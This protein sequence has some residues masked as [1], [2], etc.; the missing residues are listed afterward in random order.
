MIHKIELSGPRKVHGTV[1][2]VGISPALLSFLRGR[3]RLSAVRVD[4]PDLTIDALEAVKEQKPASRP[5]PLQSL[6]PFLASLASEA[7]GLAVEI[8][9]GRLATSR[10]GMNLAVL[11]GLDASVTVPPTGPRTLHAD[12]RVS[13]S[14]L[15][16]RRTDREVL[17]VGGLRVEG[18]LEAGAG[19]TVVTLS[20]L[21]TESPRFLAEVALSVSSAGP[22]ADVTARGSGLDVT[23]LRGRLLS[24]AGD[25][26]TIAA[27]FAIF[28]GGTLS[29]F[30]FAAGG[31]TPGDLGIFER[32]SIQAVLADGNVRIGS[33][34]LDLREAQ[35]EVAVEKGVLSAVHVTARLGRS[36]VSDGSVRIGLGANDDTLQVV[37]TVR[38]DLA[39]LPG[40]LS[41]AVRGRSF[42]EKLSLVEDLAGIAT[43]RIT[44]GDR[45]GALETKVSVSEMQLSGRYR[46]IPW[47]IRIRQ[48]TFF[49]DGNRVGV[50]ELSGNIGGSTLSGLVA[51]VRLGNAPL[52]EKVSGTIQ[53]TLDELFPWLA[54]RKGMEA[55]QTEVTGL[56]GSI[57]L[58]VS[59]LS[60]PIS[61]PA[62]WQYEATGSLKDLVLATSFLP[63]TL[64]VKSGGFRID[65]DT[66]RVTGLEART[67]DA[68]LRVSGVLAGLRRGPRKAEAAVDGVTGPEAVGWI[69][70]KASLPA[71]FLPAA[72]ITLREVRVGLAEDTLT[73]AG[74]FTFRNGP[75]VELDVLKDGEGTDVRRLTIADSFSDASISLGLRRKELAVGFN[76]RL[77][78]PTLEEL[79]ARK[80]RRHG[81]IEGEF[82]AL[83][84]WDHIGKTSASGMLKAAD[85]VIPTPAGEITIEALDV[86]A[87]GNRLTASSSSLA[88]DD[89]HLSL[90]G[91]VTFQEEGIVLDMDAATGGIAWA[92]VEKVLDRMNSAKKAA[93]G[94]KKGEP[95][96]FPIGGILRLSI[97]SFAFRDLAWRPVLADIELAKESIT[98]T[99]RKAEVCGISTTG[100]LRFL[101]GG[102]VSGVARVA[103]M[104]PDINVPL[105]C[106]GFEN[107]RMTGPY[108]ASLQVEGKG[109]AAELP[110][111]I[112][113]PLTFRASNGRMGKASVLTKVLAAVNLTEVFK[114]KARDHL[115]ET[116]PF[117]EFTVE[118]QVENGGISIRE[119]DLKSPSFTMVGS[120]ALDYLD[121]SLDVMVL[122]HPF[123]TMDKITQA[124]PVLRKILGGNFLSVAVKVTGNLDDPKVRVSPAK[125]VGQGLVNI[126]TRTV[127]LPVQVIDPPSQ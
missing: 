94:T 93:A 54:S 118:G 98:A 64:E 51:R 112:Q 66:I 43:A 12:L 69:W 97:D 25:D 122:A 49:Y 104:G 105:T 127:K 100:E 26:P 24:F 56:R 110:R 50:S 61:R 123:S 38:T 96:P 119:A 76:G 18:A 71:E 101:S 95:P 35:G 113:G 91:D 13:A 48:G 20:R 68:A 29:S 17:E 121:K 70:E 74:T 102:A 67:G 3:F 72:P 36:R 15:S 117:D 85:L 41:R 87:G 27:I 88:L 79:F 59:E 89:Q 9:G 92:R 11:S 90:T 81:R 107:A 16:L 5:D 7:S 55:L 77:A 10:N 42:H 32:M 73:L 126:L 4:G 57:G 84:P 108:E 60:G 120:G 109:E 14:S 115:G 52:F 83:V 106:L 125:D 2:S 53:L 80:S 44:I 116:I 23:A 99:V 1:R 22:R 6:T 65:G 62:G 37:A 111:A 75:R 19:K 21:S 34:G 103:S 63:E 31:K 45:A 86:R 124:I 30:S 47:P 28:Q 39:E 78:S 58:S 40:I 8:R 33:V 46:G 114:G 82:H